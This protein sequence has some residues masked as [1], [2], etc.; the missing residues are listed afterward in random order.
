MELIKFIW[1]TIFWIIDFVFDRKGEHNDK[2]QTF[3]QKKVSDWII[4]K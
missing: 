4:Y 3:T 2:K 1:F